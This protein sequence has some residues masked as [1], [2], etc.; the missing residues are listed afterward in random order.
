MLC[1]GKSLYIDHDS[2]LC[3][4]V[5][6]YRKHQPRSVCACAVPV[7]ALSVD[8]QGLAVSRWPND[9]AESTKLAP[10]IILRTGGSSFHCT[11]KPTSPLKCGDELMCRCK[12]NRVKCTSNCLCHRDRTGKPLRTVKCTNIR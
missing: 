6:V 4:K 10:K 9:M 3:T 11:C 12:E 7:G 8:T 1:K 2:F 5:D